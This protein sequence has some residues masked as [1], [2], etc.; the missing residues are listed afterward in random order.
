MN[1]DFLNGLLHGETTGNGLLGGLRTLAEESTEGI[2]WWIFAYY[3]PVFAV[4]AWFVFE[5]RK[6]LTRRNF[7][8][9]PARLA[10]HLYLFL[11]GMALNVIGKH[12]RKYVPILVG[13]WLL[14]F[15]SN[16]LGLILD[17]T[18]TAEWSLNISLAIIVVVF[19]Q[20]EGIK[21]NGVI[22]HLKHFA[23]PKLAGALVLV[24]CFMFVVE[25][26]SE[27]M[28]LLS[29][30]LRLYGNIHGGHI[31]VGSLNSIVT[32][33]LGPLHVSLPLGGLLLPIKFFTCLIQA[34]VFVMLTCTYLGMV[35]HEPHDEHEDHA[36]DSAHHGLA[37]AA[38]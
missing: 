25:I 26:I 35:T 37:E 8:T 7:T 22:G 28:K 4:I 23:G 19:V 6:G 32:I 30:S 5:T 3:V 16:F 14:I 20:I 18:P 11:T 13:F 31:L 1:F 10:E 38:A 29:L 15:V 36:E 21:Q 17:Y 2:N 24:S 9:F 34:Y 12:G 27:M 33:P